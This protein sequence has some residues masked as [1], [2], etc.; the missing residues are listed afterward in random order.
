[1]LEIETPVLKFNSGIL[2]NI[3]SI[4]RS[5]SGKLGIKVENM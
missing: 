3:V 2:P 1:V 4:D 5:I